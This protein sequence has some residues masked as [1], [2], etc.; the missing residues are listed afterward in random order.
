MLT[1]LGKFD[2][3]ELAL[4]ET[5]EEEKQA[6]LVLKFNQALAGYL[7]QNLEQ[8]FG[9]GSDEALREILN[10]PGVTEE[11]VIEYY[12]AKVPNMEETLGRLI[13]EFKRMFLVKLY[14]KKAAEL[15][16]RVEISKQA[17]AEADGIKSHII[18]RLEQELF[19]WE[20]VSQEAKND[21]WDKVYEVLQKIE[22]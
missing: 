16:E 1:D 15:K 7:G 2:L 13:L 4:A 21:N 5:W 9:E 12:K 3:L 8:Y 6:D 10:D 14:E 22:H 11:R 17:T 18:K 19:D 20:Q